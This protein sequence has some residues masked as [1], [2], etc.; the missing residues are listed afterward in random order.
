MALLG[1]RH[2]M[3]AG[4]AIA[5]GLH[6]AL[7][8]AIARWARPPFG[9]QTAMRSVIEIEPTSLARDQ[10]RDLVE[11]TEPPTS[12][13]EKRRAP[14]KHAVRRE[15]AMAG[16]VLTRAPAEDTLDMTDVVVVGSAERYPGGETRASGTNPNAVHEALD[17]ALARNAEKIEEE[18]DR[19]SA[20][21]ISGGSDWRCPFPPE[22]DE[23]GVDHAVTTI[24]VDVDEAGAIVRL[25]VLEDPGSG[26]GREAEECARRKRFQSAHDRRGF[27]TRG[28]VVLRVSFD[29]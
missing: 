13:I 17:P 23:G 12:P 20:A 8:L 27:P 9:T 7:G 4:L 24:Q 29:R 26:F 3:L 10:P 15:A 1:D 28:S 14:S 2:A 25:M 16:R 18:V 6:L 19:S 22:A 11:H 21:H 5:A